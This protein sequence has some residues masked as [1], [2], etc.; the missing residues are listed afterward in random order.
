MQFVDEAKIYVEAGKGGDGIVSFRREKYIPKG[1]PDGGDGGDGGSVYLKADSAINTLVNFRFGATFKA[2][3]GQPGMGSQCSGKSG[4]DLVIPAPL[5][6]LV[7][8][9]NTG[10]CLGDLVEEG[11]LLCVAKGGRHGLGNVHF[12]SSRH[13]APRI[14]TKGEEGESRYLYLELKLLADVGLVGMPNAGKSTLIRAISNATPKIADYPF[15]TLQPHLGVVRVDDIQSFLMADIP[16]LIEGA[17]KGAGLGVQFLKHL[18]RTKLLLHVIDMAPICGGSPLD[19]FF[20]IESEM[21]RFDKSL[22]AKERWL[23]LNKSDLLPPEEAEAL[24]DNIVQL[25]RW[26][27]PVYMV[28]AAN[29]KGL[30]PLIGDIANYLKKISIED[31]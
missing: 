16:G 20:A 13:R 6:T 29:K 7:F 25:L 15:T 23:V 31:K 21:K 28:S 8:D 1:G 10:E 19:A 22:Y 9:V 17:A 3:K 27:G 14:S 12:K 18:S 26:A 4:K 5:G 2:Q 11:Q 30:K 24:K